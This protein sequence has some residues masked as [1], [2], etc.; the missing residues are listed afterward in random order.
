MESVVGPMNFF[1]M[2][3]RMFLLKLPGKITNTQRIIRKNPLLFKQYFSDRSIDRSFSIVRYSQFRDEYS[4]EEI[5]K[6]PM[7]HEPLT[8]LQCW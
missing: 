8:K 5:K 6:S 1:Q 7:V 3:H 4:L 2:F